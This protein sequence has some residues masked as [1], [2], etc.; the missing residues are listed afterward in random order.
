VVQD[1]NLSL[2]K[3]TELIVDYRKGRAEHTLNYLLHINSGL[4]PVYIAKL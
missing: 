1:N 4:V 3:T 2:N